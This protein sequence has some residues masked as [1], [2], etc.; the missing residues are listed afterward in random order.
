VTGS[1]DPGRA[2][3]VGA[4]VFAVGV[5]R[6]VAAVE[7][8]PDPELDPVRPAFRGE[9]PLSVDG[10]TDRFGCPPEDRHEGVALGL[11]LVA[12]NRRDARSNQL[13]MPGEEVV[14][15]LTAEILGKL[16]GALDVGEQEGDCSRRLRASERRVALVSDA[17]AP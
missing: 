14:P 11:L 5:E 17:A 7:A 4:D 2:M 9:S 15:G 6:A 3:D 10:G 16:R 1:R 8:H 13:A 12:A